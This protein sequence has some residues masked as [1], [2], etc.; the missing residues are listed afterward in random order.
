[1]VSENEKKESKDIQQEIILNSNNTDE[2]NSNISEENLDSVND[3]QPF[4][5]DEESTK[6]KKEKLSLNVISTDNQ[7]EEMNW[8][9]DED[10]LKTD[11]Y[12][13][14]KNRRFCYNKFNE[15]EKILNEQRE[16]IDNLKK[17]LKQQQKEIKYLKEFNN[18]LFNNELIKNL[19][20]IDKNF[21][22]IDKNIK[23]DKLEE[24]KDNKLVENNP[25]PNKGTYAENVG[26]KKIEEKNVINNIFKKK[27]C[28][29]GN[30]CKNSWKKHFNVY[31]HGQ[32][33]F[34]ARCYHMKC[35]YDNDNDKCGNAN[36]T[37][38]HKCEE[39][40]CDDKNC[41]KFNT[42]H[43]ELKQNKYSSYHNSTINIWINNNYMD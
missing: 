29:W 12:F 23:E 3:I 15:I 16:E 27:V 31:T 19:N 20:N 25:L 21:N 5:T 18:I 32:L 11:V 24:E 37:F 33:N 8:D 35:N 40:N 2:E 28:I 13:N 43:G 41:E 4:I 22:N 17:K 42:Y 6:S 14:S 26:T 9:N 10:Q 1:M 39:M 7:E 38:L 30:A 34:D 36:C